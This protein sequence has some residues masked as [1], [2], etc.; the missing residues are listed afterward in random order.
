MEPK[1]TP[2]G[3]VNAALRREHAGG[4]WQ[5][6]TLPKFPQHDAPKKLVFLAFA[7]SGI[8]ESNPYPNSTVR[9]DY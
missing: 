7:K 6:S 2:A 4:E 8:R 5:V 1:A 9:R 3:I